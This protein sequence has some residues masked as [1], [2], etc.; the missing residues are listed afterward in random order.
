MPSL[1]DCLVFHLQMKLILGK[2]RPQPL[3]AQ[4]L[5]AHLAAVAA[6]SMGNSFAHRTNNAPS[7][8]LTPNL[9]QTQN[10]PAA[11]LRPAPGPI[12]TSHSQVLFAPYWALWTVWTARTWPRTLH[13]P[14]M[15]LGTGTSW[16]W[17]RFGLDYWFKAAKH[18]ELLILD[19][20]LRSGL[21]RGSA[22]PHGLQLP[23]RTRTWTYS[24]AIMYIRQ[25]LWTM[26]RWWKRDGKAFCE[27]RMARHNVEEFC[28]IIKIIRKKNRRLFLVPRP[29][30]VPVCTLSFFSDVDIRWL[31]CVRWLVCVV[32]CVFFC[33]RP[34]ISVCGCVLCDCLCVRGVQ[35]VPVVYPAPVLA[36]KAH[37]VKCWCVKSEQFQIKE[38]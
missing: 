26:Q 34:C 21:D 15:H 16:C 2:E 3:T 8:A 19:L 35:A 7:P 33:I 10:L 22:P 17:D 27:A 13:L 11:L 36:T 6:A 28:L 29:S 23:P 20:F 32:T 25:T 9:F 31:A 12:R 30:S 1:T 38:P 37:R 18:R 24:I 4:I 5:P 14:S